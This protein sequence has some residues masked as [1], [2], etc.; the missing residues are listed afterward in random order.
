MLHACNLKHCLC[1]HYFVKQQS[2]FSNSATANSSHQQFYAKPVSTINICYAVK[3]LQKN[4]PV[5]MSNIT[6][7]IVW[8]L[9]MPTKEQG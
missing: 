5:S 9:Y 3:E 1:M 2:C 8:S 7:P 6:G 4:P